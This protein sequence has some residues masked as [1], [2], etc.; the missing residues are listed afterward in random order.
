[1]IVAKPGASPIKADVVSHKA[2]QLLT[3]PLLIR[4]LRYLE[5]D[6]G[7]LVA[8]TENLLESRVGDKVPFMW[9]FD[10][11]ASYAGLRE[12]LAPD[13]SPPLSIGDLLI[14]PENPPERLP[15]FALLLLRHK[16]EFP[17]PAEDTE[18]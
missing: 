12:A 10:C 18:L 13:V 16:T 9:V 14:N 17:L 4:Y 3:S 7:G 8:R 1:M 6:V 11:F 15:A 2:R 5:S